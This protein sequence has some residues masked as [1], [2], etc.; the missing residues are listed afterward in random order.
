MKQTERCDE[1]GMTA[2]RLYQ[3]NRENALG[4]LT[5]DLQRQREAKDRE[6]NPITVKNMEYNMKS[7]E[8]AIERLGMGWYDAKWREIW[9][10]N[11]AKVWLA[12]NRPGVNFD[13]LF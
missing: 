11:N 5:R 1:T 10:Q 12:A 13:A 7:T 2:M 3:D 6:L 4:F 9:E 8:D